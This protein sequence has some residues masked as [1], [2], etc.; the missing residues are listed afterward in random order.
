MPDETTHR[1]AEIRDAGGGDA[2]GIGPDS[3]LQTRAAFLANW[4]WESVV[5]HNRGV[6]AR[7]GAQHGANPESHAVIEAEWERFRAV[8]ATQLRRTSLRCRCGGCRIMRIVRGEPR[9]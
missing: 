2:G 3:P 4:R 6:C 8:E 1:P 7:G 9:Q 5:G